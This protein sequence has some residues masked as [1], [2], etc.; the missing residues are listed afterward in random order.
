MKY[1]GDYTREISFPIGGIGTGSI[2][3]A[4]NGSLIDW[5]IL[6]RPSK[7]SINGCSH[8]TVKAIKDG[9]PI[10]FILNGDLQKD[11]MGQSI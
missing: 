5:E 10:T 2:G 4:G 1:T 3:I 7:G 6:N 9:K 8:F 11:L